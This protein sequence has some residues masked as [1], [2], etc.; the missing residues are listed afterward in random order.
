MHIIGTAGNAIH[1]E[2][3]HDYENA[4][5]GGRVARPTVLGREQLGRD[6]VEHAVHD[7]IRER[8]AAASS[9]QGAR[10]TSVR[11]PAHEEE[12]ACDD[13]GGEAGDWKTA[14]RIVRK[15]ATVS[16]YHLKPLRPRQGNSTDHPA[17][18]APGTPIT[19]MMTSSCG[20]RCDRKAIP[21]LHPD[22]LYATNCPQSQH[23]VV[24]GYIKAGVTW[25]AP[26]T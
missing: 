22:K 2:T 10:S 19:L 25:G 12:H 6:R 7:V 26:S 18:S 4:L 11:S 13:S 15:S 21:N 16:T 20:V 3:R 1:K 8:V 5:C 24:E 23:R 9:T 14:G 17:R